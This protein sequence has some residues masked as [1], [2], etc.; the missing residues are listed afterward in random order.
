MKT[1][2]Q[3][4]L[5]LLSIN[6]PSMFRKGKKGNFPMGGVAQKVVKNISTPVVITPST[7]GKVR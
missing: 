3:S 5:F 4:M 2:L 7:K 1:E 6:I